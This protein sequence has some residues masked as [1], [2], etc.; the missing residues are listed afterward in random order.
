MYIFSNRR[1][2]KRK[3]LEKQFGPM[4]PNYN[5]HPTCFL[6]ARAF[7]AS[8]L[9][10]IITRVV[11]SPVLF[12]RVFLFPVVFVAGIFYPGSFPCYRFCLHFVWPD[13]FCCVSRHRHLQPIRIG[14]PKWILPQK[15]DGTILFNYITT[16]NIIIIIFV[17]NFQPDISCNILSMPQ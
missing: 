4:G 6:H 17:Y 12:F 10:S 14:Q 2:T 16:K 13:V 15:I 9:W 8:Y 7:S 1:P 11:F 5:S 3:E